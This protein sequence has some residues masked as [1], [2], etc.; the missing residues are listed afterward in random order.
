[1]NIEKALREEKERRDFYN[2]FA[3]KYEI[4][5]IIIDVNRANRNCDKALGNRLFKA[6]Q[7]VR[8][9]GYDIVCKREQDEEE[10]L[11]KRNW[12]K[13]YNKVFNFLKK[14]GK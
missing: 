12:I 6:S 11:I 7:F 13:N 9:E 5:D 2:Q 1:M 4:E 8:W 10:T 3:P 14:Q